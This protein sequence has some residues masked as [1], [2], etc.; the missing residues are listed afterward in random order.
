MLLVLQAVTFCNPAMNCQTSIPAY[1]HPH[2][3]VSAYVLV[4]VAWSS[5]LMTSTRTQ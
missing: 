1:N 5:L 3:L 2:S 4:Y